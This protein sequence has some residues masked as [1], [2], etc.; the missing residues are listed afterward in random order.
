MVFIGDCAPLSFYQSVRQL[1]TS[2]VDADA[3]AGQNSQHAVLENL[4]PR[5]V[6]GSIAHPPVVRTANIPAMIA[7]YITSTTG[8]VDLFD[9]ALLTENMTLW[10]ESRRS[11]DVASIVNYLVL[12][13]GAHEDEDEPGSAYFEYAKEQAFASLGGDLGIETVQAFILITFYMLGACQIN[14]A[15][16][17][18]G[19]AVRAA[20]AIGV[21]R[22][23]VNAH[24]GPQTGKQ[25]DRLWKS[26]RILDL[27]LSTSMG[28]PPATSD[29]DCTVSYRT[30][31]D[32]GK[33]VFDMLDAS[34]QIMLVVE[35]V[36]EEIYSRRKISLSIT[37]GISMKLREWSTRWLQQLKDVTSPKA[38]SGNV[39]VVNG[40]C[41]VIATYCYA[42][43]LVSRPFL[44]YELCRRLSDGVTQAPPNKPA[45]I[46]GRLKLADA[47]IDAACLMVDTVSDLINRGVITGRMPLLVSWLFASS[48]VLGL[49]L[50]GGFGRVLEKYART[51][52]AG[53]DFFAK[54]DA[55]A[56]Q[57]SVIAK[58]LLATAVGYLESREMQERLQR[59]ASSSQLFGLVPREPQ[60]NA[61]MPSPR[62]RTSFGASDRSREAATRPDDQ[63][64][65]F[66]S[67]S[68]AGFAE[69][70]S[71][72]FDLPNSWAQ[73]TDLSFFDGL[74]DTQDSWS[75]LNLFPFEEGGRIDLARYF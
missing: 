23:E 24:F 16:L 39:A 66:R 7:R 37:D 4:R 72:A 70:D 33:D 57:Y 48:L 36:V 29:V 5:Q 13:I 62:P 51:S 9:N 46:S 15:F 52:I 31:D 18:F 63:H 38:A 20:Y 61:D 64:Q 69:M 14:S 35:N 3:F 43:M 67:L 10:A 54:S 45:M 22:T 8:L 6:V 12:A 59:T 27:F 11:T 58:S 47:C 42:V 2:R 40:A 68:S 74:L 44:M 25:R 60:H 50:L 19:V 26:L 1:V 73:T 56:V 53:L 34:V 30:L 32:Q 49:G 55:H 65:A 21:H 17:Y 28:R 71:A 41:Q 75:T